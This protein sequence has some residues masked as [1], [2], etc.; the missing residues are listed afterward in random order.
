MYIFALL[1]H[2][3]LFENFIIS[4]L[5]S[6][7]SLHFSKLLYVDDDRSIVSLDYCRSRFLAS[8]AR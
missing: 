5:G 3:F 6:R 8:F 4:F 1:S 7:E 2:L